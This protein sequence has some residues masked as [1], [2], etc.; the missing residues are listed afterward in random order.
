M[1]NFFY[2]DVMSDGKEPVHDK[3]SAELLHRGEKPVFLLNGKTYEIASVEGYNHFWQ[4]YDRPPKENYRSYLLERRDSLIPVDERTFKGAYYTPLPVVDKA[5]D[6]LEGTLG[7][8]WQKDYYVW[9]MCCGVGN[10]ETKHSNHRHLFMSTLDEED[11]N[12]MK[13][14]RICVSAERFQYDYLNDDIT[15]EGEI[16]YGLTGKIPQALRKI[17][18]KTKAGKKKLLVLINPPYAEATNACNTAKGSERRNKEGVAKT[19]WA[20]TGMEAYGKA[21]NEL[22]LQFVTRVAKEIPGAT[23]GMFSTLKYVNAQTCEKFRSAWTAKYLGGFVVHSKAF[24]GLKGDFPI[25]FLIWKT[26]PCEKPRD[27]FPE[28]IRCEVLDRNANPVGEKT[29]YNTQAK[30]CLSNWIVRPKPNGE[31]CVPL[32]NAFTPPQGERRDQR[33]TRW[34]DGAVGYMCTGTNDFQ[35]S[36]YVYLLSSG[37]SRGHGVYVN[38]EN[39]W[40]CA[41][42]FAM[43]KVLAPTWLG[44]RDQFLA[45]NCELSE[46]F[47]NDCLVWTLFNGSNLS[48][49]ASDLEWNGEKWRIENHFIPFTE[50]QVG[51]SERF[52]SDFMVRYLEG[53]VFSEEARAV[54]EEGKKIWSEYFRQTFNYKIREAFKLDRPDVGWYQIRMALKAQNETG[55]SLPVNFS[56][57][58]AAYR[59]LSDKLRQQVYRYGFLK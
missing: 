49:S 3:L 12:I 48:A 16:D 47:K 39:L 54:L 6:L 11:V 7:A 15:D 41:V 9:D 55:T 45:P 29:F 21:K 31:K 24:D 27:A 1:P 38:K 14:A 51:A 8:N 23:I 35:D 50:E 5:Y 10:L 44:D 32:T 30:D 19:R 20:R 43:E 18:E 57:F 58:E 46:D 25:G 22:F 34:S 56:T 40:Q 17:I 13:A 26:A 53:K 59:T 36:K 2:A 42:L 52:E 4:I 33:G 28:E 37:A